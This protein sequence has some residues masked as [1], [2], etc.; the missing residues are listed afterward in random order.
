MEQR[1]TCCNGRN[2]MSVPRI[3]CHGRA[4]KGRGWGGGGLEKGEGDFQDTKASWRVAARQGVST[5]VARG[6]V[7]SCTE[8]EKNKTRANFTPGRDKHYR[9]TARQRKGK[10]TLARYKRCIRKP[11]RKQETRREETKDGGNN[12]REESTFIYT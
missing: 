12:E 6:E 11:T 5:R 4:G 3:V 8:G 10:S 7:L 1:G 2:V 9:E